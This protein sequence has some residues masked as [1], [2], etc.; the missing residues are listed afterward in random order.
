MKSMQKFTAGLL[1]GLV[2]LSSPF[3][4]LADKSFV[5][6]ELELSRVE[7]KFLRDA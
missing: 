3:A 4:S 6:E 5:N 1:V 2:F 7:E